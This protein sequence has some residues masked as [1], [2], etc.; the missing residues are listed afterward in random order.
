MIDLRSDTVTRPTPAMRQAMALAEVGD[1]VYGE[2]PTVNQLEKE[3]AGVFGKEAAILVPTGTMGNQ[4]A[5]R[6]HTEHG[7]EVICEA[8][9]HV[10]DWEMA[11]MA[12]F[13]GCQAR[14][15]EGERGVLT[16]EKIRRAIGPKIYYR[17]P[18]GLVCVENTHNMAGGTVTPLDL[19]KEIGRGAKEAGLP[20]HLDGARVFNAATTL[21]VCVAEL[22]A[23]FDTVM[24]CLSKGLGAP[25]GSMLVGS[26][27]AIE[28]ARVFRKALGGGMRQAGVLAAAGLIALNE[29][30]KRLAEDHANA[31]LLAEAVAKEASAE[32]DLDSVE[33][34]IVIFRLRGEADAAAFC[35]AL[36]QKG[37]LASAIGPHAV[38]FVTHYDVSRAACEEATGV[39]AT[40]LRALRG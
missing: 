35:A 13:S 16:W 24:F 34:N 23:G 7:Q 29:M 33:T 11:M 18:T 30:P 28:R 22:T 12:A 17:Q 27:K 4:I 32:I 6:L 2:D 1:D 8:R 10:L 5:I 40:E 14:T 36:K 21:G 20:V 37:V 26:A 39:I 25:V 15:V 9:S 38:R 19:M 3:A 31:R